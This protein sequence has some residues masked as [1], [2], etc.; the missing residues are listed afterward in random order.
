MEELL[1]NQLALDELTDAQLKARVKAYEQKLQI[2]AEQ[3]SN[4]F[5]GSWE[6]DK[7][8][9]EDFLALIETLVFMRRNEVVAP[10]L[11]VLRDGLDKLAET[12]GLIKDGT[13]AAPQKSSST[14][15]ALIDYLVEWNYLAIRYIPNTLDHYTEFPFYYE[16]IQLCQKRKPDLETHVYRAQLGLVSGYTAWEKAGGFVNTVP[17]EDLEYINNAKQTIETE[18]QAAIDKWRKA[19]QYNAMVQLQRTLARHYIAAK[20][21]NDAVRMF[22]QLIDDMK[23]IKGFKPG[24]IADQTMEL[25]QHFFNHK[26]YQVAEKY[27]SEALATYSTLGEEYDMQTEQASG[28]IEHCKMLTTPV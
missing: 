18:A 4:V 15:E 19:K 9:I 10:V 17:S 28:W 3:K 11:Y 27:F 12:M 16:I 23:K 2:N 8:T 6:Q 20:K 7:N 13:Y 14:I 25:A 5:T 21:P 24:D 1:N 22:K 26:K